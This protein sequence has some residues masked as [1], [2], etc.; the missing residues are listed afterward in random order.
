[1]DREKAFRSALYTLL[2]GSVVTPFGQLPTR[3]GVYDNK[4]NTADNIFILIEDQSA[5][6][7]ADF[8]NRKWESTCLLGLYHKQEDEYTREGVDS[9]CEQI[10]D[11]LTS[12]HPAANIMPIQNG[13]QF[14]NIRLEDVRYADFQISNTQTICIKYL[15]FNFQ[16]IKI[17]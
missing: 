11:L 12:S 4:A 5:Q 15:T 9:M 6:G 2:N 8:R 7:N 16:S 14:I 17:Q 13:W 3:V 1:M 10:E